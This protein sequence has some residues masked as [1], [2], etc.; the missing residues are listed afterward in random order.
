MK[1]FISHATIDREMAL[2]SKEV[3]ARMGV[4]SFVAHED[5]LVS[6]LWKA[7]ILEELQSCDIF[8]CL[9]SNAFKKS[10]WC[11]QE[12]GAVV[13][14][15]SVLIVPISLD[16]TKP[17]GFIADLQGHRIQNDELPAQIM[18]DAVATRWPALVIDALIVGLDKAHSFRAA[19]G[20]MAP[21]QR[22]FSQMTRGQATL[23]AEKSIGNGQ[24]WSANLCRSVYLPEFLRW[25]KRRLDTE[26]RR[27]LKYQIE[28]QSWY[29][30]R[31]N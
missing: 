4:E 28:H 6:Q 2:A 21:L 8:V 10:K 20:L 26:T 12:L 3:L 16:S 30:S 18:M 15:G 19:E 17:Y 27:A 31:N 9:L 25:N 22:Y 29:A 1:A 7:R 23:F 11:S 5:L 13:Q 14:R 24:I